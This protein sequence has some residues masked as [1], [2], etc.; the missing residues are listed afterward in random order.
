LIASTEMSIIF[1]GMLSAHPRTVIDLSSHKHKD[2]HPFGVQRV[3][4]HPR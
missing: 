2:K 3:H 4:R 1:A